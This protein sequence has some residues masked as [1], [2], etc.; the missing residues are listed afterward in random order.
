MNIAYLCSG[1]GNQYLPFDGKTPVSLTLWGDGLITL[2][3]M[4][5]NED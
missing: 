4:I 5:Y 3:K 1:N 2:L